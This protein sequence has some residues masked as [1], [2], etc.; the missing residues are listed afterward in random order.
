MYHHPEKQFLVSV[1][2]D[3][4]KIGGNN[5]HTKPMIKRLGKLIELDE[6]M[7]LNGD[8]YLGCKQ[9]DIP[10]PEDLVRQKTGIYNSVFHDE[11]IDPDDNNQGG[12]AIPQ[13]IKAWQYDVQ[14]HVKQTVDRYCELAGVTTD[15]PKEVATPNLDDHMLQKEDFDNRGAHAD[16]CA[17]IVLKA[18]W[19]ARIAR[20]ELLWTVNAL[21]RN[22]TKWIRA[23]DKR[24]LRLI[25]Y[26]HHTSH[27]VQVCFV[28][29]AAEH[30]SLMLF[31]DASFA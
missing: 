26:M 20:P 25:S 3:D 30:C 19:P 6:A 22:V 7:P 4:F 21:A 14:G 24:L 12:A 15:T 9:E 27:H 23:D 29:D 1:Y 5:K 13:H 10:T 8:V 31:V 18:L 2:V 17:K 11:K 16:D 28:G